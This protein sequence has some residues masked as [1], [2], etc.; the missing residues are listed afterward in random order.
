MRF[1]YRP[2]NGRRPVCD[3]YVPSCKF[4]TMIGERYLSPGK[5][6]IF[7]LIGDFPQGLPSQAI[8]LRKLPCC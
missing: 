5:K 8:H 1:P 7:F 2:Q 4:F 6:Y 3:R